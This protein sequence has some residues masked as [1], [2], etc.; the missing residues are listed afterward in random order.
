MSTDS[1]VKQILARVSSLMRV[2]QDTLIDLESRMKGKLVKINKS[3]L[4]SDRYVYL[5]D[6]PELRFNHF[7]DSG[8][9]CS[10]TYFDLNTLKFAEFWHV[11][12][13]IIIFEE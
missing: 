5:V 3:A 8:L 1:D 7:V 6:V 11:P 13:D 12:M 10:L 4:G 2:A 9:H